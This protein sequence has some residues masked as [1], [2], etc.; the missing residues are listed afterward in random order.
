M[1]KYLT[2][3]NI[4]AHHYSAIELCNQEIIKLPFNIINCSS[5]KNFKKYVYKFSLD[6]Q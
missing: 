3:N 2:V 1:H 4:H 6:S 5:L